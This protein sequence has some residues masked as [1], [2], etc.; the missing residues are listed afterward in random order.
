MTN[1]KQ[2]EFE[3][4]IIFDSQNHLSVELMFATIRHQLYSHE[5]RQRCGALPP[6]FSEINQNHSVCFC[7]YRCES[8][9]RFRGF[10]D[11]MQ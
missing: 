9:F 5:M 10:S 2:N 1:D 6:K 3:T 4:I 7:M 11:Q 8:R